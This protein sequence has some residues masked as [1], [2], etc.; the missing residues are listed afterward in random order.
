M[1]KWVYLFIAILFETAATTSL[2]HSEGFSKLVPTVIMTIC[3]LVSFYF[4]SISL[5]EIPLGIAYVIWGAVGGILL[6]LIGYFVFG[7][8][9]D[10]A[11]LIGIGLIIS[12]IVVMNLFS[13]SIAH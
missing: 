6:S 3:Y 5:K 10:A 1:Y 12:G 9:L 7:Q 11:A 8:K 4:L 2:K 13:K